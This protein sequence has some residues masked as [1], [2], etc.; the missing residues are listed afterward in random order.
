MKGIPVTGEK[1]PYRYLY[2]ISAA[3]AS[4]MNIPT[5]PGISTDGQM[6]FLIP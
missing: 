3:T 2:L 4:P 5:V 1:S 6:D